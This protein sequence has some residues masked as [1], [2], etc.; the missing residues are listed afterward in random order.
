M[1]GGATHGSKVNRS[2]VK[3]G[4][5]LLFEIL[6]IIIDIMEKSETTTEWGRIPYPVIN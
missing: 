5:K 4:S 3:D 6:P 1:H 2:Q